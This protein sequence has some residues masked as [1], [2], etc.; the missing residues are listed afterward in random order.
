MP[1]LWT[2]TLKKV[3]LDFFSAEKKRKKKQSG[4]L[5]NNSFKIGMA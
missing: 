3:V 5:L 1:V 4:N 2:L